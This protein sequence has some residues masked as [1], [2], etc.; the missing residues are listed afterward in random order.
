MALAVR[1]G[2]AE[3]DQCAALRITRAIGL[4]RGQIDVVHQPLA[5]QK[6]VGRGAGTWD[7]RGTSEEFRIGPRHP[8]HRL[9]DI[10][11][12]I[13]RPQ[14]AKGSLAQAH[15]L[16]EHCVKHR[17]EVAGRAVDDLQYLGG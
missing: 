3:I 7:D 1:C 10:A 17:R 11:L 8:P 13:K 6:A 5:L 9:G 4:F 16:F 12:F 2:R 15:R 14:T